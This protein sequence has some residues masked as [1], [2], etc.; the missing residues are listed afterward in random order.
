VAS[1]ALALNPPGTA[2]ASTS[3]TLLLAIASS[4]IALG[5][6][7]A[8][9]AYLVRCLDTSKDTNIIFTA[10][11]NLG[12]I[13]FRR[14]DTAGAEAQYNRVIEESGGNAEAHYRLGEIY[15]SRGE[16]VRSRAEWRRAIQIDP[17]HRLTRIRLNM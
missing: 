5:E 17:S 13:L 6:D 2:N 11:L 15:F 1:F 9:Q 3:D 10:R 8:A 14:G 4:Y 7:E 12:E 16:T